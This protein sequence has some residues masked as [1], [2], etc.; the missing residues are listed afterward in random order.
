MKLDSLPI[1]LIAKTI[2]SIQTGYLTYN[3]VSETPVSSETSHHL[4]GT[5]I[6]QK[7]QSKFLLCS[8]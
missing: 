3:A 1:Q 2:F 5:R 7:Q 8:H 4:L 6:A